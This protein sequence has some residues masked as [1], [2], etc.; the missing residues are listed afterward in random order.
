MLIQVII[1]FVQLLIVATA[2]ETAYLDPVFSANTWYPASRMIVKDNLAILFSWHN[3][4][5]LHRYDRQSRRL[6]SLIFSAPNPSGQADSF[7][8]HFFRPVARPSEL[9][10]VILVPTDYFSSQMIFYNLTTYNNPSWTVAQQTSLPKHY[11]IPFTALMKV[12][13]IDWNHYIAHIVGIGAFA[14]VSMHDIL[15]IR[16]LGYNAA[17]AEL[18]LGNPK[19][20][21]AAFYDENDDTLLALSVDAT[22]F[23]RMQCGTP[24]DSTNLIARTATSVRNRAILK[25]GNLVFV[26]RN[27]DEDQMPAIELINLDTG[28][29]RDVTP[30]GFGNTHISQIFTFQDEWLAVAGR[31][32]LSMCFIKTSFGTIDSFADADYA[33]NTAKC[34]QLNSIV[35]GH[36]ILFPSPDTM[37]MVDESD[38]YSIFDTTSIFATLGYGRSPLTQAEIDSEGEFKGAIIVNPVT[39]IFITQQ[40]QRV[41]LMPHIQASDANDA[42]YAQ[43]RF[44]FSN[45]PAVSFCR[46]LSGKWSP[47]TNRV[48]SQ[49]EID[50]GLISVN[51]S[52]NSVPGIVHT[53]PLEIDNSF[54]AT[55]V[56]NLVIRV[57]IS[58]AYSSKPT[59]SRATVRSSSSLVSTRGSS[60]GFQSPSPSSSTAQNAVN[61]ASMQFGILV[62]AV[63]QPVYESSSTYTSQQTSLEGGTSLSNIGNINDLTSL[64]SVSKTQLVIQT[65]S[66]S[67]PA[68][69]YSGKVS[70]TT[71]DAKPDLAA[72]IMA[73]IGSSYNIYIY[74][75]IGA[76]FVVFFFWLCIMLAR[77]RK[78][79]RTWKS[80]LFTTSQS[81]GISEGDSFMTATDHS[82][83]TQTQTTAVNED[84]PLSI[85]AYKELNYEDFIILSKLAGGG[86]GEVLLVTPK[87]HIAQ[88]LPEK[89]AMKRMLQTAE[90]SYEEKAMFLQEVAIIQALGG[91]HNFAQMFGFTRQPNAM[92]LK[93]YHLGSLNAF[94]NGPGKIP[95]TLS[96]II[97]LARGIFA[98]LEVMHEKDISHNDMKPD[99][100]LIDQDESGYFAVLCD[101][102]ISSVNSRDTTLRGVKAF[103]VLNVEG[104]T[105][106]FAAPEILTRQLGPQDVLTHSMASKSDVFSAGMTIFAVLT[107]EY[108]W[109][110]TGVKDYE[111]LKRNVISGQRPG[112]PNSLK[113]RYQNSPALI[114]VQEAILA[115]WTQNYEER[116]DSKTILR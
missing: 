114:L 14:R 11:S 51:I 29:S 77:W 88:K 99:N 113:H 2:L 87:P 26:G 70:K 69:K 65:R 59:T 9:F 49:A 57:S 76:L 23:I 34:W 72:S 98:G 86:A 42:P 36:F 90:V 112:F 15:N 39:P 62:T 78:R 94:I 55:S 107:R 54:G 80:T 79:E 5:R 45:N 111:V 8:G 24:W 10:A 61:S 83:Q 4:F 43:I 44:T 27:H 103:K 64:S 60:F 58:V 7:H 31:E 110:S 115:C 35:N 16:L 105:I 92:I 53:I 91:H 37:I 96:N 108:P 74:M 22:G 63:G 50:S 3:G 66:T 89:L 30:A 109:Q 52:S 95:G 68:P 25:Y 81:L 102:S 12:I 101:F 93:F 97:K 75:A 6:G 47:I 17:S 85:P 18:Y 67:P 116:P 100:V 84:E 20:P 1:A 32:G 71:S 21:S 56:I 13:A 48:F 33:M 41:N 28:V 40:S 82:L 46:L 19:E 104:L 38:E 73:R 106:P